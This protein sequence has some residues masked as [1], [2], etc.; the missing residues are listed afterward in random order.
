MK[1]GTWSIGLP[2]SRKLRV[3][4]GL[5]L[6]GFGLLGFLPIVGFWM[7]PVGLLVLS[8]DV[9][10]VRRWR[11]VADVRFGHWANDNYPVLARRLG[12]SGVNRRS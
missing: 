6:I 2:K 9:P 4:I 10:F 5:L 7:I 1:L 12:Y 8:D 3:L 11:R